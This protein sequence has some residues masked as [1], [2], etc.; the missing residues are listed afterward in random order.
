MNTTGNTILKSLNK[1]HEAM[2]KH[3]ARKKAFLIR[4]EETIKG[5]E[6]ARTIWKKTIE[7]MSNTEF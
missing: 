4:K 3:I 6:E 2:L 5:I 7:H 1:R